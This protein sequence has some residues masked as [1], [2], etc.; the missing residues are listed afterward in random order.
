MVV[1]VAIPVIVLVAVLA[2]SGRGGA[3]ASSTPVTDM[4]PVDNAKAQVGRPAPDFELSTVD[5]RRVRLSQFRGTPVVLTFFASWCHPCEEELPVLEK[6]Q[7][8]NQGRLNVVGVNYQ[9]SAAD[10]R[11]F[12]RR[13]GV[14]F[15]ALVEDSIANPVA[16]RYGVHGLPVT[17]FI[18]ARGTIASPPLFGESSRK[19]LQPGL[20]KLLG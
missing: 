11:D 17:F 12:V 19:A 13:L 7:K 20:D 16:G 18:D 2:A 6:L 9:D 14:T 4:P 3:K 1:S 8:E 10:T 15:P 5:G